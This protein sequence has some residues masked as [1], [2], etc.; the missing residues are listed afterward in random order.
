M[1]VK[2]YFPPYF[3]GFYL[4]KVLYLE[5]IIFKI[6]TFVK[7]KAKFCLCK[8]WKHLVF[9]KHHV[10]YYFVAYH[11]SL[12]SIVAE[13]FY[14]LL[15]LCFNQFLESM[16]EIIRKGIEEAERALEKENENKLLEEVR[17]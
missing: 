6:F 11:P 15:S 5:Y 13:T 8:L 12:Q 1:C 14:I 7:I 10:S 4:Q 16:S 2:Q 9:V 3:K 17:C